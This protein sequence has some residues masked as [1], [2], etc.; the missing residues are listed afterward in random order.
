MHLAEAE[1][2]IEFKCTKKDGK[3]LIDKVPDELVSVIM[4]NMDKALEG[5]SENFS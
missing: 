2:T 3:W 4:G 1:A 5:L